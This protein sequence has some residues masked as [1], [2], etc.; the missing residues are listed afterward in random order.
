MHALLESLSRYLE[1]EALMAGS[2]G[3]GGLRSTPGH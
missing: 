3:A 2:E 1:M